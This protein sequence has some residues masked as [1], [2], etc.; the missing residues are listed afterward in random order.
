MLISYPGIHIL[1]QYQDPCY[2]LAFQIVMADGLHQ[3]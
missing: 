1:V 2:D 3:G